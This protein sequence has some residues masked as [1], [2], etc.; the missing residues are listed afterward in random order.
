[1]IFWL[2][3]VTT[4]SIVYMAVW[5]AV[6]ESRGG[7]IQG[8]GGAVFAAYYLVLTLVQNVT[9]APQPS[10]LARP[11]RMGDFSF[12]LLQPLHPMHRDIVENIAYKTPMLAF[13][14]P[15][16]LLMALIFEVR[17]T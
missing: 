8:F 14:V 2:I 6:A 17:F 16:V 10:L 11:I 13:F 1:M 9:L 5:Q 3:M 12:R 7:A 4:N 15:V